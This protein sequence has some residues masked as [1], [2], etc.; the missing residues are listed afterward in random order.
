[1]GPREGPCDARGAQRFLLGCT[2]SFPLWMSRT[3]L[4]RISQSPQMPE[5]WKHTLVTFY[6]SLVAEQSCSRNDARLRTPYLADA[7]TSSTATASFNPLVPPWHCREHQC[8]SN[9]L[10]DVQFGQIST[11]AL[12]Q[13]RKR[14][15]SSLAEKRSLLGSAASPS[16]RRP[17]SE[18]RGSPEGLTRSLQC[19]QGQPGGSCA[20]QALIPSCCARVGVFTTSFRSF[21]CIKSSLISSE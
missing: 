14:T 11:R 21:V 5:R 18:T 12:F 4:L 17:C 10:G 15:V 7:R 1:M 6:S 20:D 13:G 19:P 9:D 8:R 16:Q 3:M 2:F